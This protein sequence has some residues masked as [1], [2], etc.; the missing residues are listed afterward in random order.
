[1]E[2]KPPAQL[3]HINRIST[4]R[5]KK[6]T[7]SGF[8]DFTISAN[9][10]RNLNL[11]WYGFFIY[12]LSFVISITDNPYLTGAVCQG[13][14]TV[15]LAMIIMGS[16]SMMKFKFDNKYLKN[17]FTIFLLFSLIT[18]A[19]GLKYD[20]KSIKQMLFDISFGILPYLV[21]LVLLLPRNLGFYKKMCSILLV[22]GYFFSLFVIIYFKIVHDPD[23][24]NLLSQ[25]YVEIFFG[26]LALPI[27][28]ILLT[29]IYHTNRKNIFAFVVMIIGL[30]L[31]IYRA[32]RGSMSICLAT[33]AG[34]GMMYLIYT[35]KKALVISL[36]VFLVLFFT[37]FMSGIKLPGMFSFLMARGDDD[38]RS[39]VEQYM[40]ASMT[41]KDWLIGK[42]MN[43]EYYCPIVINVNDPSG[44]R[45]VI[46]TGYLQIALNGGLVTLLLFG[47]IL[48]PA[49]YKGFFKSNNILSKGAAMLILLWIVALYPTIGTAFTMHYILVW[50]SVGICYSKKIT[51]M[52]DSTIKQYLKY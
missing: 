39:G 11:F 52:S 15:G 25:A 4:Y 38:T 41:P 18:V 45:N 7:V 19:R 26:L 40:K 24:T 2:Y 14:Q 29:Y 50:I 36:S 13:I 6:K 46:E 27:G 5:P 43:G 16:V 49:V 3:H 34:A 37:I 48:I 8:S 51:E 23:W 20:F 21:P 31:L 30:Y 44:N 28:F 9:Q 32:R 1:M 42:G 47:L 35:K 10:I 17:V 22:F 12:T 33:L